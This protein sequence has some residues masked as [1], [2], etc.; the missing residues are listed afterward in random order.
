MRATPGQIDPGKT[1]VLVLIIAA[2]IGIVVGSLS[3]VDLGMTSGF[4]P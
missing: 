2:T 1:F 3:T 4:Y